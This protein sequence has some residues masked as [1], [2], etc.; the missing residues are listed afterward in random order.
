MAILDTMNLRFIEV[1]AAFIEKLGYGKTELL[2]RSYAGLR[3]FT[4]PVQERHL[5]RELGETGRI[6]DFELELRKADGGIFHGLFS[7][8]IIEEA[9]KRYL[10]TVLVDIA[11]QVRLREHLEAERRRLRNIIDGT[12]LG[13]WEWEIPTGRTVFNERWA[14]IVGYTLAELEPVSIE[15]WERLA[16]PDDLAESGRRLE[17]HFRGETEYYDFES[18]MRHKD[19]RWIWVLDRG[20]VI[21][22]DAAGSPLRMFG[23]HADIT[24]RK[25][26]EE[27]IKE[28]SIRDPLTGV[29]NRRHVFEHLSSMTAER[30]RRGR[31]FCVSILDIDHFKAVN[32]RYGHLAGDFIL[33][34]F[35]ALVT[36]S[37][38]P[39][40]LLGRYGGEEFIIVSSGTD[41]AGTAAM[42]LRVMEAVRGRSFVHEGREIRFTFSAG[43][44][45]SAELKPGQLA[46]ERLVDAADRR[47]YMAKE[48]GRD[49]LVAAG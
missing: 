13:T 46:M 9:G 39:Y 47:L 31:E 6:K 8:E 24:E 23:T 32:D 18:R 45:D 5:T 3:L 30:E 12:R 29:Y 35:C 36:A 4:N 17:A 43:L 21:D 38:R 25:D 11:E 2:G 19:G 48:G 37:I 34:E 10:L 15:T 14:E 49:R 42:I 26:L 7:A 44:V 27:R 20:R 41:A 22:R 1:N 33:R 28:S 40:D 16:H